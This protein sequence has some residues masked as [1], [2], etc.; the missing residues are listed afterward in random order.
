MKQIR[1]VRSSSKISNTPSF[2]R[3]IVAAITII[4]AVW[5]VSYPNNALAAKVVIPKTEVD[6]KLQ[7]INKRLY[8]YNLEGEFIALKL[9][10]RGKR[11]NRYRSYEDLYRAKFRK[12]VRL[13]KKMSLL[14]EAFSRKK[15]RLK[16]KFTK[17]LERKNGRCPNNEE[18]D[19]LG[20]D[21]PTPTPNH[22]LQTAQL[23][24][25]Y[26]MSK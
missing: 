8:C 25:H 23:H 7:K 22:H 18:G 10:K 4:C 13:L 6:A 26:Q 9:V 15:G 12:R 17:R 19:P 1:A 16:Q 24:I 20:N 3:L 5:V 14:Q 21:T 2:N 11:N